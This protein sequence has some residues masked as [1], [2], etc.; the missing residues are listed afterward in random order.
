M[1]EA[2]LADKLPWRQ[3]IGDRGIIDLRGDGIMACWAMSGPSPETND[4]LMIQSAANQFGRAALSHLGTGDCIWAMFHRRPAPKPAKR[5]IALRAAQLVNREMEMGYDRAEHWITDSRLYLAHFYGTMVKTAFEAWLMSAKGGQGDQEVL[6]QRALE[7]FAAF[8]DS[9]AGAI[10]LNPMGNEWAFN[11]LV[12]A[13]TYHESA[14]ALP[15]PTIRLNDVIACERW[16]GGT[17]PYVNGFHLRPVSILAYPSKTVPQMLAV[18]LRKPGHMTV[19]VRYICRDPYD[20]QK[21]LEK[22]KVH[23]KRTFIESF[24]KIWRRYFHPEN[25]DGDRDTIEQLANIDEAA[26]ISLQGLGFGRLTVTAIICD[27]DEA[28]ADERAQE[29]RR[30]CAGMGMM[31]RIED[32]NAPKAIQGTWPGL[33]T[34]NKRQILVNGMNLAEMVLP[35]T[36]W[37]GLPHI[38]SEFYEAGTPTTLPLGGGGDRPPFAW[39]IAVDQVKSQLVIGPTGKGKSVLLALRACTDLNIPNGRVHIIDVGHSSYIFTKLMGGEYHDVGANDGLPL[40]PLAMLDQDGGEQWLGGWFERMFAKQPGEYGIGHFELDEDVREDFSR[41]LRQLHTDGRRSLSALREIIRGDGKGPRSRIRRILNEYIRD[42]GHIFGAEQSFKTD[43]RLI[44]YDVQNLRG[45]PDHV[46]LPAMELLLQFIFSSLDGSPT[47]IHVDEFWHMA[48]SQWLGNAIRTFR[49]RNAG[50]IGY[51]QSTSEIAASPHRNLFLESCPV[52]TFLPN[53]RA[54]SFPESYTAFGL[55]AHEI[56]AIT[57]APSHSYFV[58]SERGS[59]L[60]RIELGPIAK[61]ILGS[62]GWPLVRQ[63]REA[64][65]NLDSWLAERVGDWYL[66]QPD[67]AAG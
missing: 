19:C 31:A 35:A 9:A 43:S 28:V 13:V 22:E 44:T 7:R 65:H 49:R 61:A 41:A 29:L 24:K 58:T 45:L 6:R 42:Y 25:S 37:E 38:E 10:T 47:T 1:K 50:F 46:G 33:W 36:Y 11:G 64:H 2:N 67:I 32:H 60:I 34:E 3:F 21:D 8:R 4:D 17:R 51:T 15:E 39:P 48:D 59:R 27:P 12:H 18:L 5:N 54:S 14:F 63:F 30:E 57:N 40:C 52:I 56:S 66:G 23:W 26:R 53:P 16:H 62:T 55:N 20:T